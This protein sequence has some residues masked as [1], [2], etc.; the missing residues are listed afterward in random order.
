[1]KRASVSLVVVFLD[2]ADALLRAGLAVRRA[3][4]VI[5]AVRVVFVAVHLGMTSQIANHTKMTATALNFA[6]E[7]LFASVAVDVCLQ[8]ARPREPLRAQM[9]FM[10]LWRAGL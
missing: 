9:A 3:G 10:F 2:G 5:F 7:R 4:L 1:M 8:T 6:L